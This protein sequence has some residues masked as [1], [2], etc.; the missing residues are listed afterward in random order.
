MSVASKASAATATQSALEG[1]YLDE[2]LNIEGEL[3]KNEASKKFLL[4]VKTLVSESL[5]KVWQSIPEVARTVAFHEILRRLKEWHTETAQEELTATLA[6]FPTFEEDLKNITIKYMKLLHKG[7]KVEHVR[8]RRPRL[9]EFL[10][11]FY[12]RLAAKPFMEDGRFFSAMDPIKQEFVIREI[13]RL[14]LMEDCMHVIPE[15]AA[16]SAPAVA[17]ASAPAASA[18]A[19]SAQAS[20]PAVTAQ[21]SAPAVTAQASAPAVTA[22]AS[23]PAVTAQ[24]SG[25]ATSAGVIAAQA[26]VDEPSDKAASVAPSKVGSVAK[27]APALAQA[28]QAPTKAASVVKS[29]A[30]THAQAQ[31][32]PQPAATKAAPATKPLPVAEDDISPWDSVSNVDRDLTMPKF[33]DRSTVVH[34]T[35]GSRASTMRKPVM[36]SGGANAGANASTDDAGANTN[37]GKTRT[38][39]L[40]YKEG[41]VD[42]RARA[43]AA[44]S[45]IKEDS[46]SSEESE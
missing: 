41:S 7:S 29:V 31:P 10:R 14:T 9:E 40:T 23:A 20:A 28:A 3:F 44:N 25:Q 38:V 5:E 11:G 4:N 33:D 21:A 34:S 30:Q 15:T 19:A 24:A 45:I 16:A 12:S 32:Q 18:P 37:K 13:V 26:A 46:E 6:R 2:L 39:R 43:A 22:Q 35:A 36:L 42:G 17:L 27:P 8:M 1:S